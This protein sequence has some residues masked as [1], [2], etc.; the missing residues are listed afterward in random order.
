[1]IAHGF[2]IARNAARTTQWTRLIVSIVFTP[3][4][5]L[6]GYFGNSSVSQELTQK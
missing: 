5:G 4:S 6:R 2:V 1:M 3:F